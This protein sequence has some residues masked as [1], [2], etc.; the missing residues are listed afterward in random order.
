MS[1]YTGILIIASLLGLVACKK[2]VTPSAS[3]D[4]QDPFIRKDN[5][6]STADHAIFLFYQKTG[7]PILYSDTLTTDPLYTLNIGYH[8]TSEDSMITIRYLHDS[9]AVLSGINFVET[10]IVPYLGGSLRPYSFLLTDTLYTFVSTYLGKNQVYLN[11]YQALQTLAISRVAQLDTL[12]AD[13]LKTYKRDIFKNILLPPLLQQ[14]QLLTDFYA[15]SAAYY[16]KYA[17]GDGTITGYIP[18]APKGT[19]GLLVDGT[20][21]SNYYSTEDQATDLTNYLNEVLVLS[22]DEFS[23]K[24]SSYP[25][26][27]EKYTDIVKALTAIQFKMP[28]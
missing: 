13:S 18:Y 4:I 7:I 15:V 14:P 8:I 1:R 22:A 16:G 10:Q 17:Y 24:Y 12:S 6:S 25:L 9:S 5:P 3:P 27:L 23:S 20:E 28:Y 11:V 19:Y 21:Y 26:V 2:E